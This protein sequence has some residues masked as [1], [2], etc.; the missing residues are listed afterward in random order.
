M[1]DQKKQ[2]IKG[3]LETT[4]KQLLDFASG[5][6]DDAWQVTAYAEGSEW[7]AVDVL[8]HLADSERGMTGLMMQIRQ[9]GEGVSADFDLNRW[10]RRAVEKL[11]DKT[12]AQLLDDMAQS[13]VRLM[14]FIDSLE[15]EDWEKEGRHGSMRIM[16]IEEICNLIADHEQSH[17][18]ILQQAIGA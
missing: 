18:I 2:E 8:R 7:R 5:L 12:P 4:R 1:T 9:G 16:T 15:P 13:R 17:L 3:K 10:N 14:D 6:S 11:Q